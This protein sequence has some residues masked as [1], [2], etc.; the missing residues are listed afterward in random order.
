MNKLRW[1]MLQECLMSDYKRMFSMENLR[2]NA[3]SRWPKETL[4]RHT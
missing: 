2:R 4:R 1:A 3:V